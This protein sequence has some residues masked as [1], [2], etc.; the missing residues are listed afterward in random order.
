MIFKNDRR[1]KIRFKTLIQLSVFAVA[2]YAVFFLLGF[3]T[4]KS[5]VQSSV[6][7]NISIYTGSSIGGLDRY[8]KSFHYHS[9]NMFTTSFKGIYTLL[10]YLGI[11]IERV[12]KGVDVGYFQL[13]NMTH[14]SNVYSCYYNLL[15]D[16]SY[17]G[18]IVVLFFEGMIFQWIYKKSKRQLARR[19]ITFF[20]LYIYVAPF[21]FLSSIADRFF[22]PFLTISTIV[23]CIFMNYIYKHMLI[24]KKLKRR[25]HTPSINENEYL[26][27][28]KYNPNM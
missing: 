9:E 13:G 25:S 3:L 24:H 14:T 4:G 2:F 1:F 18:S 16:F 19:K 22:A 10:G 11:H 20:C 26:S 5:Q 12:S 28:G 7:E 8:I 6:F 27:L 15:H 17:F 23:F 21:I